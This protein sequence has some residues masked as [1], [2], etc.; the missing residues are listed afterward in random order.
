MGES[1]RTQGSAGCQRVERKR[2]VI[3]PICSS[4]FL[5]AANC[6]LTKR[7]DIALHLWPLVSFSTQ[8]E[9]TAVAT[10]VYYHT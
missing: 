3:M 4:R 6:S 2:K 5:G 1:A 8:H 10:T 7:Q 9:L